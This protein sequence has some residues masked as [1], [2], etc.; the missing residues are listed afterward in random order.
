MAEGSGSSEAS[1]RKQ[2]DRR[3]SEFNGSAPVPSIGGASEPAGWMEMV[4]LACTCLEKN[5]KGRPAMAEVRD[6]STR[7]ST[8]PSTHHSYM[9]LSFQVFD[10]LQDISHLLSKSSSSC[11]QGPPQSLS[12]LD[13]SRESLSQELS[14]REPLEDTYQPARSSWSSSSSSSFCSLQSPRRLR[15]PP[16]LVSSLSSCSLSPTSS[17]FP[18]PCE[19]DESQSFSQHDLQPQ[20]RTHRTPFPSVS[21]SAKDRCHSPTPSHVSETGKS[22]EQEVGRHRTSGASPVVCGVQKSLSPVGSLQS[23]L[24]RPSGMSAG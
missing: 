14:K 13:S 8:R 6:T 1:W 5:R 3:L 12:D 2:L 19:T 10:K 16:S 15:S 9:L 4:A 7:P 20:L 17:S 24:P 23:V 11:P 21:P 18:G 22:V